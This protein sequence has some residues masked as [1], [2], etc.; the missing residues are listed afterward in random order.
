MIKDAEQFASKL[1]L[2]LVQFY[3]CAYSSE[4]MVVVSEFSNLAVSDCVSVVCCL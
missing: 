4:V 3:L 2:A 1:R